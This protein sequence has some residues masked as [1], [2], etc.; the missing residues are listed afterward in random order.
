[1]DSI[2]EKLKYQ[3]QKQWLVNYSNF[4]YHYLYEKT[5]TFYREFININPVNSAKVNVLIIEENNFNFIAAF[6]ASIEAKCNIFLANN[7]WEEEEWKQ[8]FN[9]VTPDI[10]VGNIK[11]YEYLINKENKNKKQNRNI[12]IDQ[13]LIMI[14]TGGTS[15]KIKFAIHTWE[16]L[17]HSVKGFSRYFDVKSINSCCLLPLY[18][19]SGLIQLMRSFITGGKLNFIA[20]SK[21]K[22]NDFP[23]FN[24]DNYFISL[25]PTQLQYLLLKNPQWL[26]GFKTILI[27]GAKPWTSLLNLARSYQLNLAIVYGMTETASNVVALKTEDFL[28]GHKSNGQVLNHSK[29][30]IQNEDKKSLDINQTGII[31][32][33]S[34]SLCL[35]YY[36]NLFENNKYFVT[37]DIGYLDDNNYLYIVG[38]NSHKI[39][40]GGENVNP[41][42]IENIILSTN[43]VKDICIIGIVDKKWGEA[44]TAIYVPINNHISESIIKDVL[45]SKLASFKHPK[46]WFPVEDI[47]RNLQGKIN[48]QKLK[49][50]YSIA[51]CT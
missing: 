36:P 42:E 47:P 9:L 51:V 46:Y 45:K 41:H 30:I 50:K 21:L 26:S 28:Q 40:T 10:I 27:G 18:H 22:K 20:Y 48:Y 15:G 19:V 17:N 14:A 8:V 31:S 39:I 49:E 43:L 2:I 29:I 25:V 38:R 3:N 5:I 33:K 11:N 23:F 1:M 24:Q 32:I 37:D 6:L 34:K 4:D 16:T 12:E 44:V 35:G 13:S 7:Q